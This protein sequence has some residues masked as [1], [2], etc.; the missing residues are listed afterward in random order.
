[1]PRTPPPPT[2]D[3]LFNLVAR[4]ERK[5]GL[6]VAEGDR[7]REGLRR[8]ASHRATEPTEPLELVDLRRKYNN[9]RK[10]AWLWKRKALAVGV[11]PA[12]PDAPP[13][14]APADTEARDALLRVTA[15]AQRW[16]HI[17]AKRQAAASIL[18]TITNKD[19]DD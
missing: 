4:A 8:F 18:T 3:Q 7:L 10:T 11:T 9:L 19:P 15:L 14:P 17:P 6:N 1:M 13:A 5:G 16:T 2:L 12:S